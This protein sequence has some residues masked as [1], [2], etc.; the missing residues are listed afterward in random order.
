MKEIFF[1]KNLKQ[2]RELILKLKEKFEKQ[3]L[4]TFNQWSILSF[5]ESLTY[6]KYKDSLIHYTKSLIFALFNLGDVRCNNC[7]GHQ[8]LLLPIYIICKITG[9]CD[10][11]DTNEYFKEMFRCLNFKIN[12]YLKKK[13]I[14]DKNKNKKL[15]YYQFPSVSDLKLKNNDFLYTKDFVTFLINSILSFFYSGDSLLI[16][17]DFLSY[18]KINFKHQKKEEDV[19]KNSLTD[20]KSKNSNSTVDQ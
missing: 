14:D 6:D 10:C 3:Y 11:S 7:N 9:Y 2:A 12:K 5:L 8:F 1:T 19:D 13:G 17:N 20:H 4:F 15:I 18:F 16:D